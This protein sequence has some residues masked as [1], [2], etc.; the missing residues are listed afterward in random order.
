MQKNEIVQNLGLSNRSKNSTFFESVSKKVL[1]SGWTYIIEN[2]MAFY[3]LSLK[4]CS[5]HNMGV[6]V[7]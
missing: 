5:L 2:L 7:H 1:H 3:K 4:K 6:C